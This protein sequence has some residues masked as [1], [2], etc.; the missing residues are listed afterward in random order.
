MSFEENLSRG[1]FLIP[2]CTQCEKIVWPPSDYCN[3]CFGKIELKK[4]RF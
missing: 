2:K 3:H 4:T 1:E